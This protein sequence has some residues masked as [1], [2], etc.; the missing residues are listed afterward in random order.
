MART[1][2]KR[3]LD[4]RQFGNGILKGYCWFITARGYA[5]IVKSEG[6]EVHGV[7]Y[8]LSEDDVPCLDEYEGVQKGAYQK[9]MVTVEVDN[10]SYDC[11]VYIDPIVEEGKPKDE[12]IER[13]NKGVEDA[14]LPSD[15]VERYI[16]KFIPYQWPL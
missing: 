4:Q 10:T 2:E 1:D 8:R 6:D 15:Y 5:N 16:R 12:Y 9:E 14:R 11:F 7:V 13:I 3:G